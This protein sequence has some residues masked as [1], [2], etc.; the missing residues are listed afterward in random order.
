MAA[1]RR[2]S[3]EGKVPGGGMTSDRSAR[4]GH[5]SPCPPLMLSPTPASEGGG[6]HSGAQ[7]RARAPEAGHRRIPDGTAARKPGSPSSG[8]VEEKD[9]GGLLAGQRHRLLVGDGRAVTGRQH[10]VAETDLS[11]GHLH[12]GMAAWSEGMGHRLSLAEE[13]R[14]H[15]GVLVDRHTAVRRVGRGDEPELTLPLVGREVL[16]LVAW[17]DAPA[18]GQQP[19][20]EEVD[21]LGPGG[22][23]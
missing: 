18:T 3:R 20:L 11:A 14:V 22:V 4:P 2:A 13:R 21:W 1:V 23:E 17:S 5:R 12:P 15:A 16:L 6:W 19:D 9:L 8:E 10:H 7:R